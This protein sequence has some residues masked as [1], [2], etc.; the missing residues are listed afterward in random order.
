DDL[1]KFLD[2]NEFDII[3]VGFLAAR[4]RETIEPLC[5]VINQRKKN[6]WLVLGGPGPSPIPE[7]ILKTT[8][9]DAVAIGEAEETIV[10]LVRCKAEKRGL[11][12]VKGIAYLSAGKAIINGRRQPVQ[13]LDSIPFPEWPLFPMDKYLACLKPSGA[14]AKNIS[15]GIVTS[16]GCVNRCNF[17]YRMEKG[18]R[19]RSIDNVVLEIKILNKNYGV[20]YFEIEDELFVISKKRILEFRDA[21][22]KEGLKIGFNCQARVDLFDEEIA[23]LL[24]EC[25]CKFLNFGMESSDQNVLNL[26]RKNT[27]VEQNIKAAEIA[28][29]IGIG[30]GLNFIWGNL[31]DTEESLS[32]NVELIKNYNT[33]DQLRTIR[34]VTPFPGSDLYYEAIRRGLL[35]GPED[36]FDKFRNSDL[37]TVNFTEI[38]LDKYYD[39]LFAANESLIID[40]YTHTTKDMDAANNLI[41]DFHDL[42]FTGKVSFRG[43]RHYDKEKDN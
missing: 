24:L 37:A 18:I 15:F 16:R 21:L 29:K 32:R 39:L 26:M 20:D 40:H 43:A 19:V 31:G 27:T 10:E 4:F 12:E 8:G 5:E 35:K 17:C 38:P 2:G 33:Y 14:A 9:V 3:A 7:Y 30:L 13:K 34:P 28:R 1:A 11:F 6:A 23:E 36:F 41:K 22:K 25:G 42:Y